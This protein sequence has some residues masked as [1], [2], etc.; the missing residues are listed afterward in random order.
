MISI[1]TEAE[2]N[3]LLNIWN[4]TAIDYPRNSTIDKIFT[5][6]V[7]KTPEKIALIYQDQEFTYQELDQKSTQLA[8][9]LQALGISKET[10]VAIYLK[11]SPEIIIS[12]LAILKA[13][14]A[15]LPLE[16]S[17]PNNR[18]QQILEDAEIN[19][20]ITQK[21]INDLPIFSSK[22]Q[23]I[24]L[25][26]EIEKI[27]NFPQN[28]LSIIDTNGDSLAYVMY[29]SGSTGKPKGVCIPHRGVIRLVKNTNYVNLD[30]DQVILQAAPIAFD[31]STFDIWGALLNGGTLV[32]MPQC[33]PSLQELG[34]AI[35]EYKITTLWLTAGLFH[36]MVTEKIEALKPLQQLLAGG[37]VL[38][39]T[40]VQ[41]VLRELPNCRFINGYGPTENTTFTCCYSPLSE[42]D[43]VGSVPI[44]YPIANTQV[45]ILDSHLQPLP[46]GVAGELYIGGD[47][48]AKGYLNNPLLTAERFI[49]NPSSNDSSTRLYKTGDRVCWRDDGAI[50]FF[51]RV[52]NQ[53]KIRGFRIELGEIES[54][55]REYPALS[56]VVVLAREDRPGD[57]R[58]VAYV[59]LKNPQKKLNIEI[60][61]HFLG[62]KLPEYMIPSIF[63]VLDQL[64]LNA[65]GKVDR[66]ILPAPEFH[67]EGKLI[68]PRNLTESHLVNI[69]Q[70][71]LG[72]EVGINQDFTSLGG[73][74]LQ[75]T[76]VISR[77]RDLFEVELSVSVML[78][79]T[80]ITELT[81][82]VSKKD[83]TENTF[84]IIPLEPIKHDH[85]LP[86]TVYQE[87]IWLLSQRAEKFPIH[88]LPMAFRLQ[89]NLN[90]EVL[91]KTFNEII[92]RHESLRTNFPLV[93]RLPI[94]RIL[95]ELLLA[96]TAEKVNQA[97]I[98]A[99]INEEASKYFNLEEDALIRVKLL[100]LTK[101]DHILIITCH[102]IISDGW[103]LSVLLKEIS[104]IYSSLLTKSSLNL[105]ELKINYGDFTLWHRQQQ[106]QPEIETS[107][108]NYWTNQL[109]GASPLLKL[110]C[111]RP[112]PPLQTFKGNVQTF[113]IEEEVIKE[114]EV[115][116]KETNTTLFMVLLAVFLIL[117]HRYSGQDDIVI[118]SPIANRNHT[119]FENLIG[120]FANVLP[121]RSRIN[122]NPS[123]KE[124]LEQI[125]KVS[126]EAYTYL[127]FPVEKLLSKLQH[128]RD[129]SYSPWFQVAFILLNV[130]NNELELPEI[131][132]TKQSIQK[133]GAIFDL[134]VLIEDKAGGLQGSIEYNTDLYDHDTITR[135]IGH[136]QVLLKTSLINPEKSVK[137][138]P[139]L[140]E[141][142]QKQIL[143]QWNQTQT[144]YNQNVCLSQLFENQ[145]EKTPDAVAVVFEE[146]EITYFQLNNRANKL[147]YQLQKLG[148]KPEVLVGIC[149][150]RS[151][152]MII[153][154]LGILKAGGAYIPIDPNYPR[155]R[156]SYMLNDG[157]ISILV[158]Q[159]SLLESLPHHQAQIVILDKEQ[160][161]DGT[162]LLYDDQNSFKNPISS[163]KPENLAYIIYTSGSTGKPKGVQIEHRS[164]INL[165]ISFQN[166]LQITPQDT[167]LGV[168][169]LSFDIAALE[170]FLP[171][172]TGAK[173]FLVSQKVSRDAISLI[174][175][176]E[177]SKATYFQATPTTWQMLLLAN[178]KGN[179]R[180]TIL[181]G[182]EA[183]P[184]TL[185][186]QLFSKSLRLFNVYGPTETTIWSLFN[187]I[188]SDTK[189]INLGTPICN[190]QIYILD[191]QLQVVPIG[192]TGEIYIGGDGLA[193]GYLNRPE[194][195][196]EKF[197]SNPFK[198]GRLYKTGDLA[199]YLPNGSIEFLGRID[200]QVK[201]RGF[202]IELGEIE[203]ALNQHPHIQEAI[204]LIR[205]MTSG[206]KQIIAYLLNKPKLQVSIE[207]LRT[208]L[209]Q[210]LPEYMI[211]SAFVFL[212]VF[213]LTPNGKIDNNALL[214]GNLINIDITETFAA[215]RDEWEIYLTKIWQKILQIKSISI[216]DNF[217][218]I[219]GDS[220]L[221]VRLFA[222]LT[223]KL[224]ETIPLA[225]I[226]KA[227]TIEELAH[228]LKVKGYLI[229]ESCIIPIKSKGSNPPLF[230]INSIN[231]AQKLSLLMNED[232]PFYGLNLFG[233]TNFFD[234]KL[235]YLTL[236]NI[237]Q[238]YIDD[239]QTIQPHG[240]YF[241]IAYCA[242]S[243]LTFE[244][245]Q[246]LNN[247]GQKVEFLGFID[248]IWG[249][250]EL[251]FDFYYKNLQQFGLNYLFIK[252]Q[253]K[254]LFK[255]EELARN[256]KKIINNLSLLSNN[257]LDQEVKDIQF[258]E[259]FYKAINNY[260]PKFY[261][262]KII[263]FIS[264]EMKF[265][266]NFT[267]TNLVE[268]LDIQEISGLHDDI[269]KKPHI[270]KLAELL[271]IAINND[272]ETH[273]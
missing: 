41:K 156:L 236:E 153:A 146:E 19:F 254:I 147:A 183:L 121:L 129:L 39:V 62:S 150:E 73:D 16:I 263:L 71:V 179:S 37:D 239:L 108:L 202:R 198:E 267:L 215:P 199:Y 205:E 111:D 124:F 230:F 218:T 60:I 240:P 273:K 14:G 161:Y 181:T 96:I 148:V 109:E 260:Q 49:A 28:N 131:N 175:T 75:A 40:D 104:T 133:D 180:L 7:A 59:I 106:K 65:N 86:L 204:V 52:D 167:W 103:S 31:A 194:L 127:D 123:F 201:I 186:I 26:L 88:N 143:L 184:K 61:R 255:I 249:I 222:E 163:L 259:E 247:Q 193:R 213:P 173:L 269:F 211:P 92:K 165:L 44:G 219:G 226:F 196:Q 100:K 242:D 105:P 11:R 166:K 70:E 176:L 43:V 91:E 144:D 117:M 6:Q 22:M 145:A 118:G 135:L 235:S 87:R 120:C 95:S 270:E 30:S 34:T 248:A 134:T 154:L 170:I 80:T 139:L 257:Y 253:K 209:K 18:I 251:T 171:L 116:R 169:T 210:K 110:P 27:S 25:D 262:G 250:E 137:N 9:Y 244:I 107:L 13:G 258:L 56:N 53:V 17:A 122:E 54:V 227:P 51:G 81:E 220:L 85:D 115:L 174:T 74:S 97:D 172:I 101:N 157:E 232:Q 261:S 225:L 130:P 84:E 238:K 206:E 155:E 47:G 159:T 10:L 24:C 142:E 265:F 119:I 57:K 112:R 126:L 69:W 76:Q 223:E 99:T 77:I 12:I 102:H 38:S 256:T 89:G 33:I 200:N 158:S 266:N 98:E 177:K 20:I 78:G 8:Y 128:D 68:Q 208:F 189:P 190:T 246:Q 113:T 151:L 221:A 264:S 42:K 214:D 231:Y 252:L 182:G 55:L 203:S 237:A 272:G 94:Q 228:I 241:L 72:F 48:L 93:N 138:L 67:L 187:Q 233:L 82:L 141:N 149:V 243:F 178:W 50:E 5:Q 207:E 4:N 234:K 23:V 160:N 36:L 83:K 195:T 192:V 114:I 35:K 164:L 32:L 245:A 162:A 79:N 125:K 64:P 229:P 140:T 46:V 268:D 90:G 152:E 136:F 15:Y 63:L 1:L 45:Y 185:A 29:T 224:D 66:H 2:K 132:I 3:K 216:K 197:I 21:S 58:L 188:D 217:F 168:T 191:E 212:D 271:Q